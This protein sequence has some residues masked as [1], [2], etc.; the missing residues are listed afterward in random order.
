MS[1]P[2]WDDFLN[3][4]QEFGLNI[5]SKEVTV[6][7]R[8]MCDNLVRTHLYSYKLA[9]SVPLKTHNDVP[10]SPIPNGSTSAPYV[11]K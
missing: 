10:Y 8:L 1:Y 2:R 9:S 3:G 11:G 5:E 6:K 7:E 4:V